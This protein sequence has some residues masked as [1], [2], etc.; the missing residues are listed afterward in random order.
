MHK[1]LICFLQNLLNQKSTVQE[2]KI[3]QQNVKHPLGM[4]GEDGLH[5]ASSIAKMH[6]YIILSLPLLLGGPFYSEG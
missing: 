1:F 6:V 4:K 2:K 5:A 3:M